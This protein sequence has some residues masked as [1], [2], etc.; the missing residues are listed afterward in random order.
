MNTGDSETFRAN[1]IFTQVDGS[2]KDCITCS[3]KPTIPYPE[4]LCWERVFRAAKDIAI[5]N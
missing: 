5:E 3:R 4:G 1:Y 2:L